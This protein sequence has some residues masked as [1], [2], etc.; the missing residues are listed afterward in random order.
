MTSRPIRKA[1]RRQRGP[2][3]AMCKCGPGRP[4]GFTTTPVAFRA[5]GIWHPEVELLVV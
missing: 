1:P 2:Q 4:H 5:H 3:C